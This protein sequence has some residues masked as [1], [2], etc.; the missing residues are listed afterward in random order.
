MIANTQ[1]RSTTAPS[2]PNRTVALSVALIAP[3]SSSVWGV[4][5]VVLPVEPDDDGVA[6]VASAEP[7]D[8]GVAVVAP[9]E[10]DDDGVAVVAPAESGED[11]LVV[12]AS[13]ESDD[14]G[15]DVDSTLVV[16]SCPVP[17]VGSYVSLTEKVG[18]RKTKMAEPP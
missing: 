16:S 17:I 13:T 4:S 2:T 15:E 18:N 1:L 7:D 5:L 12:V 10:P 14:E 8:D 9:A 11:G 3:S 6:V